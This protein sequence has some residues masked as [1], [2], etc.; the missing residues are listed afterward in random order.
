MRK[1]RRLKTKTMNGQINRIVWWSIKGG[2]TQINATMRIKLHT[3]SRFL[4]LDEA[5]NEAATGIKFPTPYNLV[6]YAFS[7][8]KIF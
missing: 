3:R 1:G 8:C 4:L 2:E 7:I 5:Q 6:V